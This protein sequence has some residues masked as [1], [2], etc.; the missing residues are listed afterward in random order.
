MYYL[1]MSIKA[2]RG[3]VTNDFRTLYMF[4]LCNRSRENESV[5]GIP[6]N[7]AARRILTKMAASVFHRI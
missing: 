4:S 5:N 6:E 7:V 3:N 2:T 1:Q